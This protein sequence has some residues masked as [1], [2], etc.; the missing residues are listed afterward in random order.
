MVMLELA[1]LVVAIA[2]S[3]YFQRF[4]AAIFLGASFVIF[5]SVLLSVRDGAVL[6]LFGYVC[7]RQTDPRWFWFWLAAHF[8]FGLFCLLAATMLFLWPTAGV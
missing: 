3:A 4:M 1:P 5:S 6:E 8:S 2:I 7:E